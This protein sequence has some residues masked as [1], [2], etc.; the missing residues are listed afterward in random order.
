M[1]KHILIPT[2]GSEFAAK[3]IDEDLEPGV[4]RDGNHAAE[5]TNAAV[6]AFGAK[7]G[8]PSATNAEVVE[9]QPHGIMRH[10]STGR[11]FDV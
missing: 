6:R 3:A 10:G 1:Y 7:D 4:A 11:G 8:N 5:T 9:P 2:D